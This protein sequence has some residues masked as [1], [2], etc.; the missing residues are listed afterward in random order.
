MSGSLGING[1]G[2]I[3]KMTVWH[4]IAR[5][6]YERLV[7]NTG[8]AAGKGLRDIARYISTDSTYGPLHRYLEGTKGREHIEIVSEERGEMRIQGMPIKV[9]REARNPKD[10]RWR[11]EGVEVVVETTGRFT[12]PRRPADHPGGSLRGHL[13]AGAELVILSA[14][15]KSHP[16]GPPPDALFSVYGIN[17][18]EFMPSRHSLVSAASCTTTALAHMMK[19]LLEDERTAGLVTASMS[20]VHSATKSQAILDS[21]PAAGAKDLRKNRAV[22]G[23][24]ILTTTNA[25][26]ALEWVIPEVRN[27]GFM[28]DSVRIPTDTVSLI[29]LNCTF[30]TELD[31]EGNSVVTREVLNEIYRRAH[32]EGPPHLVEYSEEQ[33]VSQDMKGR[34]AAVVI[35]GVETHTRTGFL[36]VSVA[37]E[38]H[39]IPVTHAKIFG[40]YDNELG[41]YANR[42]GDLT[43][44]LHDML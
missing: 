34:D 43:A 40:W 11:E 13:A 25:A 32:E 21:L 4:H 12:D 20:T 31:G 33:N 22:G 18:H 26:R 16:D 30:Q 39:E 7:V 44:A 8:R 24:I 23:N 29:I 36:R 5:R 6:R 3:G 14:A 9:L 17:H 37:G 27:T 1:L 28:A 15:F 38:E 41:S 10:I 19:P 2:R 35:E 42:L